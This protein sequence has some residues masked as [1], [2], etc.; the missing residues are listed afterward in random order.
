MLGQVITTTCLFLEK[1]YRIPRVTA[2][3]SVTENYISLVRRTTK[4]CLF[5]VNCVWLT[6][7]FEMLIAS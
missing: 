5:E 7:E 2:V 1:S 6:A 4:N 3:F